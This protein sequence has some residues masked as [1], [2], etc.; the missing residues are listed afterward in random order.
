MQPRQTGCSHR[1]NRPFATF[2]EI[3]RN[4][5]H[6]RHVPTVGQLRAYPRSSAFICGK[7]SLLSGV[8]SPPHKRRRTAVVGHCGCQQWVERRTSS[9]PAQA[10]CLCPLASSVPIPKFVVT[11]KR[12]NRDTGSLFSAACLSPASAVKNGELRGQDTSADT[13]RKWRQFRPPG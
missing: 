6:P 9:T 3:A 13:S 1:D 10:R 2:L 5:C 11:T 7:K 12:R 4:I 8:R